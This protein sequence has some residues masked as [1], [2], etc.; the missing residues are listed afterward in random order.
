VGGMTSD[1]LVFI[2]RK[3]LHRTARHRGT[4]GIFPQ[5][6]PRQVEADAEP[7]QAATDRRP[8]RGADFAGCRRGPRS[9]LCERCKCSSRYC[10][11]TS[12]LRRNTSILSGSTTPRH[13]QRTGRHVS[14]RELAQ[15][16]AQV[17]PLIAQIEAARSELAYRS[18]SCAAVPTLP[19]P[20]ANWRAL[21]PLSASPL[22]TCSPTS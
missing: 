20:N 6:V 14:Q 21:P 3:N 5:L 1:L 12:K 19:K 17:A 9:S 4:N 15:L 13:Y 7:R 16:Q 22:Q 11:T 8:Q 18:T 10:A 2:R